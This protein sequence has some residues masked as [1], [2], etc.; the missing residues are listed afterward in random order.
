MGERLCRGAA[1]AR[2]AHRSPAT[3]VTDAGDRLAGR[4]SFIAPRAEFTPRNVQT[5]AERAKLVYRVKVTVDNREGVLKPGMPVEVEF[6]PSSKEAAV[7]TASADVRIG[8]DRSRADSWRVAA[9]RRAVANFGDGGAGRVT[10]SVA[11]VRCSGSSG[12]TAPARRRLLR[13]ICGLLAPDTGTVRLFG[14]DPFRVHRVATAS[15]RIRLAAVQSVRGSVDRREH[16]VLRAPAR[17]ARFRR[18]RGSGCSG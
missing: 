11:R 9:R 8:P 18:S 5:V 6:G 1:G 15:D 7:M 17:R 4:M 3:I 12:L 2:P 14:A 10:L 13:L 16:R